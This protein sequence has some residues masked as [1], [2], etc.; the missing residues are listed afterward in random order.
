M[1]SLDWALAGEPAKASGSARSATGAVMARTLA[2][3]LFVIVL[4]SNCV[5]VLGRAMTPP[6]AGPGP[7]QGRM[8]RL[9]GAV[10]MRSRAPGPGRFESG[11]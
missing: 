2:V 9:P 4:S 10:T 5:A 7:C 3:V 1:L 8:R 11:F 6:G